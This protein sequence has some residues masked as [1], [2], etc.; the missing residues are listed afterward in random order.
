MGSE[1]WKGGKKKGHMATDALQDRSLRQ[2]L[3]GLIISQKQDI[4]AYSGGHLNEANLPKPLDHYSYRSWTSAKKKIPSLLPPSKIPKTSKK[5]AKPN[6]GMK[7]TLVKFSL[8]TTGT[9]PPVKRKKSPKG[10]KGPVQCDLPKSAGVYSKTDDGVLVEELRLPEY[11]LDTPRKSQTKAWAE[12]D[13]KTDKAEGGLSQGNI[14]DQ[15]LMKFKK[16]FVPSYHDA[17][18][19]RDQYSKFKKFES[20]VLQTEDTKETNVFSGQRAVQHLETKLQ[21]VFFIFLHKI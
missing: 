4:H 9:L 12:E 3:D 13:L 2:L 7:D 11:L 16:K 1:D 10:T 8:G 21:K 18:T 17:V 14:K 6:D 15:N 5:H 20:E 19:K